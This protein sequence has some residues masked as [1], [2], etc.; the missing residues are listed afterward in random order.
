MLTIE[1]PAKINLTLEVLNKL[2]DGF[3]EVRTV[4]QTVDLCDTL[5]IRAG[6]DIS[7]QCDM[8]GWSTEKSL[9]SK[10]VA[11]L[12]EVT[13]CK[14]GAEINIEKRIPLMSGLGGDSSDAA[15][16]LRG[17]NDLWRLDLTDEKLAGMAAKL[18]SDVSF[19]LQGGTA[20]ATGKGEKIT[21]LP[22][23]SPMWLVLV[24]PELTM[25]TGKT[26]KMYASLKPA[27]FTDGNITAKVV[28]ALRGGKPFKPSML[29]NT[30]ENIAFADFNVRRM[31]VEHLQKMGALHVHLTGSGPALF[32]MFQEKA[33]AEDIYKK[34]LSQKMKAF[35]VKTL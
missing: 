27:H 31:Y 23:L 14:Q 16:L 18:G 15:A 4:L 17:L 32:T 9:V 25:A 21:P 35:P 34:C 24:I 10:T 13:D 11:L 19:F 6:E 20:L 5:H 28:D 22:S 33:R 3:H 12:Q 30:F 26:G 7:F 8:P 2:P 29:F 1:A